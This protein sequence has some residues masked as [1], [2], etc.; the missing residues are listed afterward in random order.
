ML[1]SLKKLL[2]SEIVGWWMFHDGVNS[3][4][5]LLFYNIIYFFT[6]H[7]ERFF[8]PDKNHYHVIKVLNLFSI[9]ACRSSKCTYVVHHYSSECKYF[10]E[11]TKNFSFQIKKHRSHG[12]KLNLFLN[13]DCESCM[14]SQDNNW[15][16]KQARIFRQK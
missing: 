12:T 3:L 7:P 16:R 15:M 5:V 8:F 14:L 2:F 11:F 13:P 9:Y 4:W 6:L 10:I 1:F